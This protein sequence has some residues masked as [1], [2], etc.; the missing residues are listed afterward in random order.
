MKS[1]HAPILIYVSLEIILL[2]Y[3]SFSYPHTETIIHDKFAC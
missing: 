2:H 3:E 1:L